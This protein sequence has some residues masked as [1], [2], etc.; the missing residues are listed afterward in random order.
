MNS[1]RCA[2]YTRYSTDRQNPCSIEDQLRKCREFA[3][4]RGWQ[5]LDPHIY[6][7]EAISG[8]SADRAALK[9]LLAAAHE[10]PRPF[11]C[12]LF[13]DTSRL[14]RKLSDS[15]ALSD[16]LRFAGVRL[17]FV[18]QGIDSDS[19]QAD[20][21]LATHGIVDSLYIREL[22]KKVYRGIEGRAL[23]SLHTGGRCFG[24]R[25]VPIEDATRL[26]NYGRPII[27]GVRLEIE[28]RKAEIVRR[29]FTLYAEGNS[30][31]TIAKKL[32]REGIS[33]PQPQ[34]GRLQQSWCPSS[35]RTMIRNERYRGIVTWGRTQK[36]RDPRTGRRISRDKPEAD[37][38]SVEV[39]AQRIVSEKL[40]SRVHERIDLVKRVF[41]DQ[42]RKGG[43]LRARAASSPYLFSGLLKCGGCGANLTI[44]AGRGK[45]HNHQDYGC[46]MAAFRGTCSNV[47]RVRRDVIERELLAKLQHEVLSDEVVEYTIGR[48]QIELEKALS[49]LDGELSGMRA[50]KQKLES[51]L[52]NLT[53]SIA[54]GLDSAAVRADIVSRERELSEMTERLLGAQ[55]QSVRA[56]VNGVRRFVFERLSDIRTLLNREAVTARTAIARHVEEITM[57][58]CGRT[59][60][61]TGKWD[62]M[63]I[64]RMDGAEGQS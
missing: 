6:T 26:D 1:V 47:L 9:R 10:Q 32:N 56:R 22:S 36:V 52:A 44:V 45:N 51:E 23:K 54:T 49:R 3:E 18:S 41:G 33:S 46:P 16:Q 31:K 48:F 61:A 59:Y 4:P 11:D 17:V 24:Y 38:V 25:R 21:L 53:R 20:V 40:W 13:D 50:R 64:G 39:P 28:P 55:P 14:A 7:D 63:G 43:L 2:V 42:G 19:E 8:A 34:A 12:V 57:T 58:A 29:I 60:Q 35:V 62:L 15:L 37:W 5:L 30:L 27:T